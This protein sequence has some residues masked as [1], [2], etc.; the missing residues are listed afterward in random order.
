SRKPGILGA[1]PVG[2]NVRDRLGSGWPVALAHGKCQP[3]NVDRCGGGRI[4]PKNSLNCGMQ[5]LDIS[6]G[7]KFNRRPRHSQS[8]L[9]RS[10]RERMIENGS[11]LA[12]TAQDKVT[13]RQFLQHEKVAWIQLQRAI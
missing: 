3:L 13:D 10:E 1:D 9:L 5:W 7:V 4:L 8:R 11:H 2:G 6:A 12:I